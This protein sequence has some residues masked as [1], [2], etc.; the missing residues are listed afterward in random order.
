MGKLFKI[1]HRLPI[2]KGVKL[3]WAQKLVD[4]EFKEEIKAARKINDPDKMAKLEMLRRIEVGIIS[5][6][7]EGNAQI[8]LEADVKI[9]SAFDVADVESAGVVNCGVGGFFLFKALVE[10]NYPIAFNTVVAVEKL[11]R[12][13]AV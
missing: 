12:L 8:E 3:E 6:E 10:R 7:Q 11:N 2:P 13:F 5:E 4:H 9:G 1:I